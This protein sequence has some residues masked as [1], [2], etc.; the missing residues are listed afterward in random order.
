M[1]EFAYNN[2]KNLSTGPT[3]FELNYEYHSWLIYEENINPRFKSMSANELW[4]ELQKLMI[5]CYKN[6]YYAHELQ[7]WA[8]NKSVKPRSYALS[9]KVW[10]NSKYIKTKQNQ[11][12]KAKFFGPF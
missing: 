11:K 9:D 7:K 10:L 6:L 8:N 12:L 1:A 3:P 5:I 4:A 2:V